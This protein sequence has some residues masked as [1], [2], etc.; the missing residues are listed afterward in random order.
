MSIIDI[1]DKV[2]IEKL[3]KDSYKFADEHYEYCKNNCKFYHTNDCIELSTKPKKSYVRCNSHYCRDYVN[4]Y[5]F[6]ITYERDVLDR[7]QLI[8]KNETE[9]LFELTYY[10]DDEYEIGESL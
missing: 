5:E 4:K 8:K 3:I 10:S 7:L 2:N 9:C 1:S 6:S